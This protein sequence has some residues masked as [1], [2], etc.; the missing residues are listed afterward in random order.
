MIYI[1]IPLKCN[2]RTRVNGCKYK[3]VWKITNI[4]G[5]NKKKITH[6]PYFARE[7]FRSVTELWRYYGRKE[8]QILWMKMYYNSYSNKKKETEENNNEAAASSYSG[9]LHLI[10]TCLF[11]TINVK[12]LFIFVASTPTSLLFCYGTRPH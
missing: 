9:Q 5:Q 10:K 7:W 11:Y 8:G 3:V 12:I 6:N 2:N 4:V 1:V